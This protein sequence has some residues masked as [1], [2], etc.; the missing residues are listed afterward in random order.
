[1]LSLLVIL[2]IYEFMAGRVGVGIFGGA[3]VELMRAIGFIAVLI[4]ERREDI[5]REGR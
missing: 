2:G 4:S 1:V 3:G 5:T